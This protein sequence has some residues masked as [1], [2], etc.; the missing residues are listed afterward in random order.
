ML[1]C[2]GE[3]VVRCSSVV[4]AVGGGQELRATMEHLGCLGASRRSIEALRSLTKR[5]QQGWW[6]RLLCGVCEVCSRQA[7]RD[8]VGQTVG[9]DGEGKRPIFSFLL[10]LVAKRTS[11]RRGA[12]CDHQ[13][14]AFR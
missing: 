14:T 6:L 12:E 5:P 10:S 9:L 8:T 3:G 4:E 1:P 2:H 13:A 11:V 7:V